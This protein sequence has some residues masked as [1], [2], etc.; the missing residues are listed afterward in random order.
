MRV[1]M[2]KMLRQYPAHNK[3]FVNVSYYS[4]FYI[5]PCIPKY[6]QM[7]THISI[8]TSIYTHIISAFYRYNVPTSVPTSIYIIYAYT[9]T[10]HL[11]LYIWKSSY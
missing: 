2:Y 1:N 9:H 10:L 3:Y 8:S 6:R 4:F 7:Y 5:S 11:H